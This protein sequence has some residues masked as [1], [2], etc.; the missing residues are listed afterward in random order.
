MAGA[1]EFAF[2]NVKI[3]AKKDLGQSSALRLMSSYNLIH[4]EYRIIDLNL[5]Q[6]ESTFYSEL[7]YDRSFFARSGLLTMGMSY[8]EKISKML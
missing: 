8:R 1:P 6:E 4:P 7:I 2:G 5:S 3:E